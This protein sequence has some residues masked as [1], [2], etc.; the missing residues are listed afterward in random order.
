MEHRLSRRV[1][2][3]IKLLIV[4]KGIPAAYGR[5]SNISRHGMFIATDYQQ[6][7]V[8]Q[9]LDV[10]L[11]SACNGAR[12]LRMVVTRKTSEGLGVELEQEGSDQAETLALLVTNAYADTHPLGMQHDQTRF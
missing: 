5:V 2:C 11:L 1:D 8:W 4:K 12:R 10:E 7:G 6:A 9:P 3:D